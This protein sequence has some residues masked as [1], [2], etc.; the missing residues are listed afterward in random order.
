MMLSQFGLENVWTTILEADEFVFL[1]GIM[2]LLLEKEIELLC[3]RQEEKFNFAPW[4]GVG[5]R[6]KAGQKIAWCWELEGELQRD[7]GRDQNLEITIIISPH[8]PSSEKP[9][10]FCEF[11]WKSVKGPYL[12][13]PWVMWSNFG[14]V[15]TNAETELW[16]GQSQ[17]FAKSQWGF[18][19]FDVICIPISG[20]K[21]T[22]WPLGH[23]YTLLANTLE[24]QA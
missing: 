12:F 8:H 7:L 1:R 2:S 21:H 24:K 5:E 11:L 16:E 3:M 19:G 6:E 10:I 15:C 4:G 17:E 23:T 9:H 20:E 18:M 14:T 13:I 22:R